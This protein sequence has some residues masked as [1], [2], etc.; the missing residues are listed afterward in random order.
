MK[1]FSFEQIDYDTLNVDEWLSLF[2]NCF[3]Q[4]DFVNLNWHNWFNLEYNKNR[5]FVVKDGPRMI[6]SYGLY[7]MDIIFD[8]KNFQGYLCH[9]VMTD[10]EYGGMGLF[11]K[12]GK[13]SIDSVS[14]ENVILLG[15]PNENA[16]RGHLK[17]GWQ[18]MENIPFYEKTN[19]VFQSKKHCV[20]KQIFSFDVTD[21]EKLISF[22]QKYKF[23]VK[24]DHRFL[25]WR[26]QK[27]P[28]HEYKIFKSEPFTSYVV[29][30]MYQDN[31][32]KIHIV[33][34]GY[35]DTDDFI[36]ILNFTSTLCA[37]LNVDILNVWC[38]H[39]EEQKF[40]LENNFVES[41][42]SN[43]L[44]LHSSINFLEQDT[45]NWHITLADNDV[46]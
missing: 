36:N 20:F 40:L 26:F 39:L 22:M 24:K 41:N 21:D 35:E 5:V 29:L 23:Y 6:A 19:F 31:L 14:G 15:I 42:F 8:S 9:N 13:Y 44:I 45:N 30:K 16:I 33:D 11:T 43:R 12:L 37:S 7:P 17:V 10:P 3:G 25:N 2:G 1:T 32:N 38:L 34:Y 18:E 28:R 27:N 46:Y 4:R